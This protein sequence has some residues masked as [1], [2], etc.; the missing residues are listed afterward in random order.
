VDEKFI[1]IFKKNMKKLVPI[2]LC[3][4]SGTRLWPSSRSFFP[5]QYLRINNDDKLSFFQKSIKR[6]NKIEHIDDPIIICN[7]EH[8]FI[9]AE[10]LR[11]LKV[12]A[13]SIILEP[14]A[15]NTAPAITVAAIKSLEEDNVS[16]L[17]ILPSDH[18]IKDINEFNRVINR[19][20]EY[21]DAGKLVTF[22]VIPERAETGYGYIEAL[23]ILDKKEIK[24]ERIVRFIEKPNKKLAQKLILNKKFSWN[25]GIF[26]FNASVYINEVIKR[27][28]DIY[29]HCKESISPQILDLDFQRI[30]KKDFSLCDDISIDKAIMEKTDLGLVLPMNVGWSDI[31]SWESIW[32]ES[33]KDV[34][35]N[36]LSGKVITDNVSNSYIRSEDRLLVTIGINDLIIVDTLDALLIV[37]KDQT[38]KVKEIV[39]GLISKNMSEAVTHRTVYRPWGSYD[40]IAYGTNW[41]VKKIIVK[42]LQSLSLQMHKH[43]SE[44]WVVVSG[45]ALVE[46]DGYQKVLNKNQGVYIPLGAKHRL[47][48]SGA[49]SLVLIEIQSGEYL[50]EDDIIRF[51]DKYGRDR[52]LNN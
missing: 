49:E 24:G 16:N 14:L 42:P 40:S 32:K 41:Q 2:I 51:D 28:P 37:K 18:L 6:I 38:Q 12:K 48:N 9:V 15:R 25:S 39:K 11:Y 21:S 4:G 19:A 8:R 3:G 46:I 13:K 52:N 47:S 22:G 7:E 29:K 26:L 10:Q 27:C 45:T 31:G 17:L 34:N 44:H 5:K 33:D 1:S 50:G 30:D 43:R 20:I 35:G 23:N 36:F